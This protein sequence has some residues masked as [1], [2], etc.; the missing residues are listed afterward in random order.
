MEKDKV[1]KVTE[2]YTPLYIYNNPHVQHSTTELTKLFYFLVFL[3]LSLVFLEA[4]YVDSLTNKNILP[5]IYM[6]VIFLFTWLG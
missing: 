3:Y 2:T 6:A 4:L 5:T 1:V